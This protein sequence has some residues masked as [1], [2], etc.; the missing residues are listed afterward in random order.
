VEEINKNLINNENRAFVVLGMHRGG[1]SVIARSL[2]V[3]GI[4]LGDQLLSPAFDNPKG[5]WEDQECVAI[6][7]EL[8]AHL[9]SAYDRMDLPSSFDFDNTLISPLYLKAVRVV[10]E[11]LVENHGLWGL[12]DPRISRLLGFWKLVFRACNCKVS[13]VIALR[14]PVSIAESL[15]AR[16]DIPFEKSYLL[17]LQHMVPSI[18]ETTGERRVVVNYDSLLEAPEEQLMR[19]GRFL[20]LPINHGELKG[21]T[22][23]FLERGLRHSTYSLAQISLD[24]RLPR[25]AFKAYE[26][27]LQVAQDETQV[28]AAYIENSF[29]QVMSNLHAYMPAFKYVD[30][31]EKKLDEKNQNIVEALNEKEETVQKLANQVVALKDQIKTWELH[32][33]D[34]QSG[35]AWKLLQKVRDLYHVVAPFDS[36]QDRWLRSVIRLLA[37]R[38]RLGGEAKT[39]ETAAAPAV[40][41]E[42]PKVSIIIPVFN[43][44]DLTQ[45]CIESIY[46]ETG[47]IGYEVIIINN[48]SRD[49]TTKWLKQKKGSLENLKVV[50]LDQNIGF[51]PAVNIGMQN[52]KGEYIVILNNDTIVAPGWLDHLIAAFEQNGEIGIAS[53]MT[54]YVGEGPQIDPGA[55]NLPPDVSAIQNLCTQYSGAGRAALRAQPPGVLLCHAAAGP[56]GHRGLSGYSLREGKL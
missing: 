45:Q 11:R 9:G 32:W 52:S 16:N 13:Y 40:S 17:W 30:A 14:D 18:L 21:F 55:A 36:Q 10:S 26:L 33:I 51:G 49:G 31:L 44:L 23:D 34:L 7:E 38:K 41:K 56:G 54:N 47:N 37:G 20:N 6:N 39:N 12:K 4:G 35:M 48:A 8:L 25:D 46:R 29:A 28:D 24:H 22:E 1:T 19:L 27:L 2:Q 3:L 5:F 42:P 53:P 15:I 43:A 50:D